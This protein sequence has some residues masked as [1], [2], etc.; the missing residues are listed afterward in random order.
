MGSNPTLA[1]FKNYEI[2]GGNCMAKK[3]YKRD[4]IYFLGQSSI[5]V[6][7]SQYLVRFGDCQILLECGLYQSSSNDYLDSYR[8]NS[9]KFKFNPKDIDF[10]FVCH[11]HIDHTGLIPRLVKEGFSGKIISTSNT[12]KIM[13]SL[14]LNSSYILNEEA[15]LLS[16]K[17]HRVYNPLYT[18][19]DVIETMKL[20]YEYDD[21]N[22][23]INLNDTVGFQWLKNSHCIGAAQLQ[24]ILK[25]KLKTKKILYT[26]DLGSLKTDNHYVPNTEIPD[27][28]SDVTICES[29]YGSDK[30]LSKKSRQFDLEH[31]RVAINTVIERKGSV[32]LPCFSFSRTQELLTN[33]YILF[34]NDDAF[35]TEIIVDSKLSCEISDLYSCI[36]DGENLNLW[37]KVRTWE[38]VKFVSDKALSQS[39][40]ADNKPKIVI[41]SSGFCTNGRVVNYLKKHLKDTNSMI[42]FSGYVGDNPSYLSYRIKNYNNR[43]TISINKERIPNKADCISLSTFSSHADH[44]DLVKYGSSLNTTKLILVHGSESSKCCLAENLREQISK[45]NKTYKVVCANKEMVVYI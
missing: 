27:A 23:I 8:I 17:Y 40:I 9:E 22:T 29:T 14:L 35:N 11:A 41:S 6:T 12:A 1:V 33:L 19:N 10:V 20:V 37:N 32:I 3:K 18:E 42:I 4:G 5:E 39:Y 2:I 21:Y 26:S 16:K 44:N 15:R 38:H 25:G 34:H 31:L 45:N 24:L 7:G 43:S 36:L 13:K 28:F 30:R